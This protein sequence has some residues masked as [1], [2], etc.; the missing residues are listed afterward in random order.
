MS[1]L[2]DILNEPVSKYTNHKM[3]TIA[4]NLKVSDAAKAMSESK[5]D[6]V[7]VFENDDVIGIV[8]LKD[9]LSDV[10]AAGKDPT[11]TLIKEIAKKPVFK[12]HKDSQVKDA[13]KIMN[14]HDIRRL[15]VTNDERA[16]GVISRKILV[17]NMGTYAAELP[18]LET[19]EKIRCPYCSS[20]F[21]EKKSLSHH[22]DDIHIGKGLLEGNLSKA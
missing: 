1:S 17:G 6:S 18:E 15:V 21:D 12:I 9:I 4:S 11:Q 7:L 10:V 2:I 13:I 5:I 20:S 22:I 16:I 19:P 8:T 3:T 14:E